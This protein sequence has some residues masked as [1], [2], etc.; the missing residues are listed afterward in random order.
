V[1]IVG[2]DVIS[3]ETF[4]DRISFGQLVAYQRIVQTITRVRNDE[5]VEGYYFGG[6][7]HGDQDGLL[8]ADR[9]LITELLA[10]SS[11]DTTRSTVRRSDSNCGRRSCRRTW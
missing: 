7:F 5:G 3:F 2:L 1:K 11:L 6:H 4:L 9:A 10:R 8:A